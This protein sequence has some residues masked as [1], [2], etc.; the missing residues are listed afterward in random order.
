MAQVKRAAIIRDE[1]FQRNF[2]NSDYLK[3]KSRQSRDDIRKF[4]SASHMQT[5]TNLEKSSDIED[6]ETLIRETQAALKSLSGNWHENRGNFYQTNELNRNF[7]YANSF[8]EK[9]QHVPSTMAIGKVSDNRLFPSYGSQTFD[10]TSIDSIANKK[11]DVI[12]GGGVARKFND[13][14]YNS[15]YSRMYSTY[16]QMQYQQ[17]PMVASVPDYPPI[18]EMQQHYTP[19]DISPGICES[20][21]DQKLIKAEEEATDSADSKQYTMLEPAGVD[22]KAASVMQDVVREGTHTVSA[23]GNLKNSPSTANQSPI[24]DR[25]VECHLTTTNHVEKGKKLGLDLPQIKTN[26]CVRCA[27]VCELVIVSVSYVEIEIAISR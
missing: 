1:Y 12:D 15:P 5:T 14:I 25:N 9:Y 24:V 19:L 22:S 11:N 18:D 3:H 4:R 21:A 16:G 8:Q 2:D 13:S 7:H 10:S 20:A 6:D 17:P 23:V 26:K 27:H